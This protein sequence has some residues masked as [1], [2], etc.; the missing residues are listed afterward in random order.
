MHLICLLS[1]LEF[2]KPDIASAYQ[3]VCSKSNPVTTFLFGNELPKH[4]KDI[5]ELNTIS[6]MTLARISATTLYIPEHKSNNNLQ[7]GR[8]GRRGPILG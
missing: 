6:R 2:F 4:I 3:S 5:G 7:L 1:R 8:R